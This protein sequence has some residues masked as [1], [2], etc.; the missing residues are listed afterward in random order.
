MKYI[1]AI[2]PKDIIIIINKNENKNNKKLTI[3]RI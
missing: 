2:T 3:I 1:F